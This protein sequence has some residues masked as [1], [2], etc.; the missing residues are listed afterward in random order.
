MLFLWFPT[1]LKEG[2]GL[3]E[4]ASGWLGSLP[5]LFGATGVLLGGFLGDWLTART[6]SRRMALG[7]MGAVGL[8][9]SGTFVGSSVRADAPLVAVLLCSIGYFFSY[10]QL[11]GWWAAV[12]DI[13]GR[14]LGAVFGLCNMIGLSGGAISQLFLG[15]F[16]DHMKALGFEGRAQWDPAFPLYSGVLLT[17]AL[18]WLFVNPKRSVTPAGKE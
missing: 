8:A 3:D 4:I 1:Y 13:G 6:G 9:L 12:G 7:G 14:H 11:A 16:A 15:Q 10:V 5:Y 2:R 18:L 17:G